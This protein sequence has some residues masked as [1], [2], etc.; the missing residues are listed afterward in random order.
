MV[1]ILVEISEQRLCP[2]CSFKYD[3]ESYSCAG[4]FSFPSSMQESVQG[5][6]IL[7]PACG[8]CIQNLS[9]SL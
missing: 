9:P 7:L 2:R 4:G 5:N 8:I 6:F 1:R 3:L